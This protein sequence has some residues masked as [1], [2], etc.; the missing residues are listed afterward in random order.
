MAQSRRAGAGIVFDHRKVP[1][2]RLTNSNI[3]VNALPN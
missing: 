1:E 2:G 3:E